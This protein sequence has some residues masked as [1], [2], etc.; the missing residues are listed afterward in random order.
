MESL[1]AIS[2]DGK[3]T[4]TN[5]AM[6]KLTGISRDKLI[7]TSFSDYF[8][9][10]QEAEQ[11]YQ[12]VFEQ[13][14]VIDAPLTLRHVNEHDSER[15]VLY[16]ASVY[17]DANGATLGVVATSRDIT[18]QMQAQRE[19]TGQQAAEQDRLEELERFQRLI[20]GRELKMIELK[21]EIEYLR[22]FGAPNGSD[23]GEQY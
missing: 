18:Q 5:E 22:K 9:D 11:V 19:M 16:N 21:K 12:K 3:I 10:P 13:G 6:V 2:P 1:V 14:S 7:G 17:R 15:E 8:T 20:V 23:I 4:D